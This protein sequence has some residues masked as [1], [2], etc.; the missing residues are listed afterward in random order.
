[1]I[2]PFFPFICVKYSANICIFDAQS[3]QNCH[4]NDNWWDTKDIVGNEWQKQFCHNSSLFVM[5][6]KRERG[7]DQHFKGQLCPNSQLA[8]SQSP[9]LMTCS[10]VPRS[11][12]QA[13]NQSSQGI[14]WEPGNNKIVT[15]QLNLNMSWSLT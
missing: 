14:T 9:N 2:E 5:Q 8:Y 12:M 11:M 4:Q 15:A 13:V 1:M 7:K 6:Y 3:P 10:I